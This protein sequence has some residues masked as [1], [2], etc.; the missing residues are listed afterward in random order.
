[1]KQWV[2]KLQRHGT[3]VARFGLRNWYMARQAVSAGGIIQKT[4]ELAGLL[5]ALSGLRARWILEIGVAEGGSLA[6]WARAAAPGAALIGIDPR[7]SGEAERRIRSGMRAEQGLLL[8][9]M[10]SSEARGRVGEWLAG[11]LLDFL[12]IDGAHDYEAVASDFDLYRPLVRSGGLI[13][14]HDI[15][16][17]LWHRQGI[18]STNDSGQVPHF[19][20]EIKVGYQH[21]EIIEE[22]DQDGFGI[23]LLWNP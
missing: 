4:A 9:A 3:L 21:H 18:R 19:W 1:M 22:Q 8:L 12:F 20:N 10:T 14:F 15:C 2:H 23:G 13:A 11:E 17:D 5:K 6:L 7:I 16:P